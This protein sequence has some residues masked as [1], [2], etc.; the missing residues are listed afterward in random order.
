MLNDAHRLGT[1]LGRVNILTFSGA[2]GVG[3]STLV[4]DLKRWAT[5]RMD[6]IR[7]S[8]VPSVST[9]WFKGYQEHARKHGLPVPETYD[10]INRFGIRE[11]MQ[12]E[13]PSILSEKVLQ[14]VDR[15]LALGGGLVLVD[16]WFGDIAAYTTLEMEAGRAAELH[17]ESQGI[18]RSLLDALNRRANNYAGSLFLTHISIPS[19]ACQHE[20]PVGPTADKAHRGTTPT[21]LWEAAYARVNAFTPDKR[22]L[23]ITSADR[24]C[25]VAEVAA[26]CLP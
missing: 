16:R 7:C 24:L 5:D 15:A 4:S 17:S 3:K 12:R 1:R 13:M 8:C 11:M 18:H 14:E 10:D 26:G 9:H 22:T 23:V 25:R 2:H 21:E 6:P 19:S 20:M